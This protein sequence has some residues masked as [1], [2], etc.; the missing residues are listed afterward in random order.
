MQPFPFSVLFGTPYFLFY[1]L[2]TAAAIE[3]N[4][5]LAE[6]IKEVGFFIFLINTLF[7]N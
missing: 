2:T 3:I 1:F 5:R 6:S 4:G 7:P